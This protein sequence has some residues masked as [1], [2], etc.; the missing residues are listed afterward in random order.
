MASP[1]QTRS[2]PAGLAN[3]A[4]P[5]PIQATAQ[6]AA[7]LRGPAAERIVVSTELDPWLP[8][9][10]LAGYSG[11]S[12]RTLRDHI[13]TP[14]RALPSYRI[15]GKVLVRRSDFDAWMNQFRQV[16]PAGLDHVVDSVIGPS[17]RRR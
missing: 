10:A 9:R 15:G 17:K 14:L 11:L 13:N 1:Q 2:Q 7:I 12:V 6:P 8:L 3:L 16:G 5:A 4:A